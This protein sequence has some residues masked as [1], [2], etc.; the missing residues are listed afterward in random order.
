MSEGSAFG[1]LALMERKPRAAT[2][3]CKEDCK[4]AILDA[5]DFKEILEERE[6]KKLYR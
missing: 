5:K 3:I 4:F 6:K 2:I 1:E